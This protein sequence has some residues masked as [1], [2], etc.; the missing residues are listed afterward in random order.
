M[1]A[2]TAHPEPRQVDIAAVLH[3]ARLGD[4]M[5]LREEKVPY[6]DLF[7]RVTEL[8]DLLERRKVDYVLVGG[9]AILQYVGG[10]NTR[11]IDLVMAVKD[12]THLPELQVTYRAG[13]F[14]RSDFHGITVD[15]LFTKNKLFDLVRRRHTT[16]IAYG[17]RTVTCATP[18]GL[19]LMKLYALPSLYRQQRWEKVRLY[20]GDVRAL[21]ETAAPPREAVVTALRPHMLASDVRELEAILDDVDRAVARTRAQPFGEAREDEPLVP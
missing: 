7:A 2:M 18:E 15:I 17:A 16:R 13:D 19:L 3:D 21:V 1:C 6:G 5:V 12:L 14:V 10:R 20:E 8:L 9:I 4:L 11:D